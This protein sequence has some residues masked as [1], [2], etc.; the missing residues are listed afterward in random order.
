MNEKSQQGLKT[1]GHQ[2][3]GRV[4]SD[5]QPGVIHQVWGAQEGEKVEFGVEGDNGW[6]SE[7]YR[8]RDIYGEFI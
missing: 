5:A 1:V 7:I 3:V 6:F 2:V 8:V 4:V